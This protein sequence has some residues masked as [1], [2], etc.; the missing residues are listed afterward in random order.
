LEAV[1]SKLF[2]PRRVEVRD[3]TSVPWIQGGSLS[4]TISQEKALGLTA[5]FAGVRHITDFCSTMPLKPYR[6]VGEERIPAPMPRLF[7]DMEAA[8]TLVP[9]LCQG[10]SST[11][12]RGNAV[13]LIADTDGFGFP[14]NIAWVSMDRV[15]VDDSTG[16]GIWYIDG[17]QV[18]RLDLVHIPWMTVPGKTL[19]LSPIE[20]H[21]QTIGAGVSAQSYGSDWFDGGGFPPAVFKN[22]QKVVS[23]EASQSIRARLA[24]SMRRKEPLVTGMDWDFTPITV[25]PEQAQFIETQKLTATQIASI[26]G[27]AP[28]EIGGEAPNSLT[29]QNEEHRQTVRAHNLAPYL[30]R[31]E[32]AFASWLPERQ[33]VRFNIDS[34]IR[35]D[36]KSRWDINK[37][38]VDMGESSLDEIRAQEDKPP[39]PD[40]QGASYGPAQAPQEEQPTPEQP[41]RLSAVRN[42]KE[43]NSL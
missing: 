39:L 29:Y 36:A 8:G 9:W 35:A 13:G 23:S 12:I 24:A 33:F 30:V 1:V 25:P 4:S 20:Y 7:A 15:H 6:K 17:R 26:F 38:R 41:P 5:F 19:G 42:D 3:I 22:T 43:G 34:M 37:I 21:A 10:F 2:G 32:R 14:T 40:G 18:S 27:I 16:R 31:F 11:V 28:D